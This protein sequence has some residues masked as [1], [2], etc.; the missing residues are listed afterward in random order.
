[1]GENANAICHAALSFVLHSFSGHR[2]SAPS[3]SS[4]N[5]IT[6][7]A[8]LS[9]LIRP[10]KELSIYDVHTIVKFF[11][12]LRFSARKIVGTLCAQIVEYYLEI[13]PTHLSGCYKWKT[14]SR[15]RVHPNVHR[16]GW[17]IMHD[18]R[19]R[20]GHMRF[21]RSLARRKRISF[22]FVSPQY[23]LSKF[24]IR[25]GFFLTRHTSL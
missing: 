25:E 5:N 18:E 16:P 15:S 2:I 9:P 11:D 7:W 20:G 12:P 19:E 3:L 1:M 21:W 10:C 17:D 14:P 22:K 4:M 6:D 8:K 24:L 23:I 13:P